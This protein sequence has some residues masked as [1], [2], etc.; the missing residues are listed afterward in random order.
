LEKKKLLA[1]AQY[2]LTFNIQYHWQQKKGQFSRM[3]PNK[4]GNQGFHLIFEWHNMIF[5]DFMTF[6]DKLWT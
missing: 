4:S 1:E 3:L 6:L 2:F 5:I